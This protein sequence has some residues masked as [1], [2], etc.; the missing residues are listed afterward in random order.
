MTPIELQQWL[1]AHGAALTVDGQPGPM[2]RAAIKQVFANPC[3]PAVTE[4]EIAALASRLGCTVPQLRAVA[5]VESGGGGFDRHGRPKILFERHLFHRLTDGKWTPAPFSQ[6]RGGG[7]DED[8]WAKLQLAACKDADAAFSACSWGKFQVLGLHWSALG[9]PSPVEM[10]Y[11]AVTSEAAHYEMLAR[12]IEHNGL[13]G[14]LRA[15]SAA[16]D[17]NRAFA[18]GYNGPQ[19][20]RFRYHIKLAEAL[21]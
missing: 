16:A 12:Y 11:S 20:E 10:A 19:F 15:L 6:A 9:Y 17:D 13:K 8:S 5:Q 18:R 1:N 2:T 7:Y 4:A 21:R 14:P 3:A